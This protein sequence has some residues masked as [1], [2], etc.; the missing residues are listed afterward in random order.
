MPIAIESVL[1]QTFVDFELIIIDDGS[2]DNTKSIIQSYSDNR[3]KY[4]RNKENKERC[5]S[6]NIGIEQASG[7][8]ICFLDSD[9]YHLPFHLEKLHAF[10]LEKKEPEAF[11]FTNSWNETEDGYRTERIC[12]NFNAYNPYVYF[13]RYTVNPQRWCVHY[14]I[15]K[16]VQFD[17]E[18]IICEDMDTSLRIVHHNFPVFH[19]DE[20]TTVYVSASDSFTYGDSN[21]WEKELFYLKKIFSKKT[22]SANFP[23]KE[24]NRLLSMCHFHLNQKFFREKYFKLTVVHG[25]KSLMLY[26]KGYN[27]KTNKIVFNN[28][29][30]SFIPSK[31]TKEFI[32]YK[33]WNF[34]NDILFNLLK[35]RQIKFITPSNYKLIKRVFMSHEGLVLKN[36]FLVNRCAFNLKGNYDNTFHKTFWKLALEQY[37]VS[38]F[39]KSLN[40]YRIKY[41]VLLIHSKWFN[42]SFWITDCLN[43]LLLAEEKGLLNKVKLIYPEEWKNINYVNESL[44]G[45]NVEKIMI[46]KGTHVYSDKLH[47]V[48][49]RKWTSSFSPSQMKKLRERIID[50]S[51]AKIINLKVADKIYLTRKNRGVRGVENEEAIIQVL[52]KYKFSVLDFSEYSFWEQVFIMRNAKCFISIHGA[53]FA[54]ILFMEKGSSVLELINE[55]YAEIEYRFP[56]YHLA[57]A[58]DLKYFAQFG[59]VENEN[60]RNFNNKENYQLY[61]KEYLVNQDITIDINR[62]EANI[63]L[64]IK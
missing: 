60:L 53:G 6:R 61:E 36:N 19:L 13:L 56:F 15:L 35:K 32:S 10:I 62:F 52:K 20:R 33:V 28:I 11:F 16:S 51:Y 63:E 3:I 7:K 22:L 12:P 59:K 29:L 45:F 39:G 5:I 40:L 38:R 4:Y 41:P 37:F 58:I 64:M 24:K 43:R 54:N 26:P 34:K 42:Y 46:P 1:N 14:K 23:Q 8:Y 31:K 30:R 21:K 18:I 55:T 17:P 9:D 57:N 48:Q 44:E 2:T 50:C 47:F 25:L 27:G 49:T